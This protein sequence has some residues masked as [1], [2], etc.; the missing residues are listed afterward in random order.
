MTLW[1]KSIKIQYRLQKFLCLVDRHDITDFRIQKFFGLGPFF[2]LFLKF[3][4]SKKCPEQKKL[5]T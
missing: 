4:G 1:Q 3:D 5:L 2:D